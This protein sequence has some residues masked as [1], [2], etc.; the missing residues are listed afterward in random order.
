MA[1]GKILLFVVL[2]SLFSILGVYADTSK[3]MD[4]PAGWGG[5]AWEGQHD[6]WCN[7]VEGCNIRGKTVYIKICDE[8]ECTRTYL[9]KVHGDSRK[10]KRFR[11]YAD[12]DGRTGNKAEIYVYNNEK[13]FLIKDFIMDHTTADYCGYQGSWR[14]CHWEFEVNVSENITG[15][16]IINP[17][18]DYFGMHY[19]PERCKEKRKVILVENGSCNFGTEGLYSCDTCITKETCYPN[20]QG[21][22]KWRTKELLIFNLETLPNTGYIKTIGGEI[23]YCYL[24]G[25]EIIAS[26]TNNYWSN[27]KEKIIDGGYFQE[28]INIL[29][30]KVRGTG[31]HEHASF[32][33]LN[34][35]YGFCE[36]CTDNDGDGFSQ[37]GESC[38]LVDCDDSNAL[39][40][41]NATEI[42]NGIDDNCNE[43]IDEGIEDI[44]TDIFGYDNV[45][46]CRVRIESC[47]NGSF[48]II[49]EAK[50]P[51][52]EICN[53]SLDNDCDGLIDGE[54]SDCVLPECEKDEDCGPQPL[55]CLGN[56]CGEDGN[57]WQLI[58]R[59]YCIENR[60]VHEDSEILMEECE[61]DCESGV[62]VERELL[63]L[64]IESG[65]LPYPI[66]EGDFP[67]SI[68]FRTYNTGNESVVVLVGIYIDNNLPIF[69]IV[70]FSSGTGIWEVE[71]LGPFSDGLHNLTL[72]IDFNNTID[73]SN[74]TNNIFFFEFNVLAQECDSNEDCG[75]EILIENYCID[76]EIWSNYSIPIC[77]NRTCKTIYESFLNNT[78]EFGCEN[79]SCIEQQECSVN[80]DCGNVTSELTCQGNNLVNITIIP[81]CINGS[82]SE[83]TVQEIVEECEF[84][85]SNG[86]CLQECSNDNDCPD[87]YYSSDYCFE[88]N[89]YR[90]FHDWSCVEGSCNENIIQEKVKECED[91]CEDGECVKEKG[92]KGTTKPN[93]NY[94]GDDF[95]DEEMGEN[96][97][98]CPED[99]EVSVF[100][101]LG[102]EPKD[103]TKEALQL[104]RKAERE[105]RI[106]VPILL[107]ILS[108]LLILLIIIL[109]SRK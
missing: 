50:G 97:F 95:C 56:F 59:H 52:E 106:L 85:C 51:E 67:V 3:I 13:E 27:V 41:P 16:K 20:A 42:C 5:F 48:Q 92:K 47:V 98:N 79:G 62:C 55:E 78:C 14:Q 12:T 45:G 74:E 31:G 71:E 89:V 22:E 88:G 54:D 84:G 109:A 29:E 100:K 70:P 80:E 101:I 24:N 23:Y 53:D 25:K 26:R 76:N 21:G 43:E 35:S 32:K 58:R 18:D 6:A 83:N 90:D 15:I 7:G 93:L 107:L 4:P 1:K 82:C 87:D 39:I 64:F 49:Q 61:D 11:I 66:Y 65:Y 68:G 72:S 17:P 81:L 63:D 94:C 91:K 36:E 57:V 34:F 33:L 69:N 104:G 102:Y 86:E 40:N 108:L 8:Y 99:C 10:V 103:L 46:E 9:N 75:E 44:I 77:M 38:G 60:C 19:L 28:G 73:E 105:K 37:E 96:E 2:F 30:C